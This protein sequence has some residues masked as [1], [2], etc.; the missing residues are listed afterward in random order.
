M[1]D[2]MGSI[3]KVKDIIT[4]TIQDIP[5]VLDG[6]NEAKEW[7]SLGE[8]L[9]NIKA[10]TAL[11]EQIGVVAKIVRENVSDINL[12]DGELNDVIASY[13][14]EKVNI[15]WVPEA[16]EQKIFGLGVGMVMSQIDKMWDKVEE[17]F[18]STIAKAKAVAISATS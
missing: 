10:L 5:E 14:N 18:G 8:I 2:K 13:I 12:D 16:V 3:T 1:S 9:A 6:M 15:P 11:V 17:R 4:N 7:N